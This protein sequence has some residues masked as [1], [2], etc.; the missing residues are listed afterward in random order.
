MR[1]ASH[2][3][4]EAQ[5]TNP[6]HR[7][8]QEIKEHLGSSSGIDSEDVN[9]EYLRGLM[10]KYTSNLVDW[11]QY[12]H[13]DPSKHYT[14]NYVENINGKANILILVWNPKKGSPV[15]DHARAHCVM[16]I[17]QGTLKEEIFTLPAMNSQPNAPLQHIKETIY[18]ADEVTYICD[19]IGLHRISNPSEDDALAVSLHLY[20]PPT[21]ADFGYHI[22]EEETGR[23]IYVKTNM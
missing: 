20:T 4:L 6:F 21:A 16:K 15:H 12:A 7:L 22:Y 23:R 13:L 5:T 14:R 19:K 11:Q 8:V 18:S 9:I 10:T 1:T 2:N 3:Y 17:L